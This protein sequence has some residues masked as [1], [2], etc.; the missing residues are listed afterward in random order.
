MI[1]TQTNFFGD[2]E[3]IVP[4]PAV[5]VFQTFCFNL[6]FWIDIFIK[7]ILDFPR[8]IHKIISDINILK[9]LYSIF[10]SCKCW[11][12]LRFKVSDV[13]IYPIKKYIRIYIAG[14]IYF[15]QFI[16]KIMKAAQFMQVYFLNRFLFFNNRSYTRDWWI[17]NILLKAINKFK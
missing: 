14:Y 7:K 9:S 11:I 15:P 8:R 16:K 5:A 3:E 13:N 6:K 17:N 10:L 2:F 1:K 12:F 4:S